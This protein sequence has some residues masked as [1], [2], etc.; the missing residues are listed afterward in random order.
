MKVK[1]E[2]HVPH[3]ILEAIYSSRLSPSEHCVILMIIRYTY[4]FHDEFH[5][6][7]VPFISKKT[8]LPQSTVKDA[9]RKL[10]Q[11]RFIKRRK[12]SGNYNEYAVNAEYLV[13]QSADFQTV[14]QPVPCE[15]SYPYGTA[16]RPV[17]GTADRPQEKIEVKKIKE[18]D[19]HIC[20][21]ASI[22]NLF[23]SICVDL[24]SV[25]KLT[26][27][28]KRAIGSAEKELDGNFEAFFKLV[29]ASD[30]LCGRIGNGWKASFDWCLKPANITKII[31]GIY[32]NRQPTKPNDSEYE[33][34]E[35]FWAD[36]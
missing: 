17:E 2:T 35:D 18:K 31:E 20:D 30:F 14:R 13:S 7:T 11:R 10:R 8:R 6:L 4:G 3:E 34:T 24:P 27:Q 21:S 16:D 5:K 23:N 26:E 12:G 33:Y 36:D 29:H 28:R 15:D 9:L 19:T 1:G 22:I 32:A 25:Q